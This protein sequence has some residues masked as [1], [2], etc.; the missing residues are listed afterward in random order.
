[1]AYVCL[2]A[3]LAEHINIVGVVGPKKNHV[4]YIPFKNFVLSRG[5]NYIEYDKLSDESFIKQIKDLNVDLAVVCSFNYKIPKVLLD[6]VKDGFVNTHPSLLPKY[7]GPNPYSAV[8]LNGEKESGMT[9]HLMDENFDTGDIVAQKSMQLLSKDTMGTLFNKFNMM[10]ADM[11]IELL[12]KYEKEPFE[13]TPQPNGDFPIA[14]IYQEEELFIDFS[15]TSSEIDRLVRSLNPFLLA[16]CWFKANLIKVLSIECYES[17]SEFDAEYGEVVQIT[18]EKV[19]IKVKDGLIAITAMQFGSFFAGSSKDFIDI[20][21]PK[22]GD[23][24]Y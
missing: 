13:R 17:S 20:V 23:K 11:H 5:Q 1:M 4:T 14:P 10:A 2:D 24:F 12:K 3:F 18:D 15:K 6:A 7:R 8:I 21:D 22:V 9:L 19:L 16:R